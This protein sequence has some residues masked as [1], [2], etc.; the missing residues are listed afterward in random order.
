MF[1]KEKELLLLNNMIVLWGKNGLSFSLGQLKL[2]LLGDI[3]VPWGKCNFHEEQWTFLKERPKFLEET[4]VSNIFAIIIISCLFLYMLVTHHWKGFKEIYNFVIGSTLIKIIYKSCNH[5][6]FRTH[7]FPKE[8]GCSLGN[9]TPCSPCTWLAWGK[10]EPKLPQGTIM[11][12]KEQMCLKLCVIITF[13]YE[14]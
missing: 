6:K 7:L 3:I 9:L 13:A 12:T 10:N 2:L 4:Y 1:S 8:H 5:K 11:F 14:L